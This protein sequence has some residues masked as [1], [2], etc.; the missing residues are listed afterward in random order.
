M[1]RYEHLNKLWINNEIPGYI[2]RVMGDE[3]RLS[4]LSNGF[5]FTFNRDPRA[6]RVPPVNGGDGE[7]DSDESDD[8][9]DDENEIFGF[10]DDNDEEE[11]DNNGDRFMGPNGTT[12]GDVRNFFQIFENLRNGLDE[13][14]DG[15]NA[16]GGIDLATPFI[17]LLGGPQFQTG[18]IPPEAMEEESSSDS[19]FNETNG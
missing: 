14:G 4:I 5:L 6:R 3:F 11:E 15:N 18:P 1:A 12:A 8:L 19:D 10:G 9:D 17:E 7:D 16:N 13:N 2:S